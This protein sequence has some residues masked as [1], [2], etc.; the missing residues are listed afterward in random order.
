M[1]DFKLADQTYLMASLTKI[2]Q[3]LRKDR[4][5]KQK[6]EK[7]FFDCDDFTFSLM[8]AFHRDRETAAMPMFITWITTL[9]FLRR[10]WNK[11]RGQKFKGGHA[12]ITFYYSAKVSIIEPQSDEISPIDYPFMEGWRLDLVCG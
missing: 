2:K 10:L 12:V 4:T 6:W 7:E 1:S 8:G 5:D 11:I 9:G 3:I